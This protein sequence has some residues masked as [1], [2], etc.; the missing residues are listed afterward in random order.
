MASRPLEVVLFSPGLHA[1]WCYRVAHLL[2]RGERRLVARAL[3]VLARLV[4]GVEIH[5]AADLGRRVVVDHGHGVVVGSTAE[6]GDDVLVYHGV[7]LGSRRPTTGKRHPTVGDGVLLGA[8]ATLLGPIE[9]GDDCRVGAGAVVLESHPPD[10]TVVG[11]P[12]S[13]DAPSDPRPDHVSG[14]PD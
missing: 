2:W 13:R 8:G 6:V 7:T 11:R 9:I 12:A 5:P 3:T 10:E 4:T 1:L 14:V